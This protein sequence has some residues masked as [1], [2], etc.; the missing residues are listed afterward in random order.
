MGVCDDARSRCFLGI[1]MPFFF[2]I[3][4]SSATSPQPE[5]RPVPPDQAGSTIM[6]GRDPDRDDTPYGPGRPRDFGRVGGGAVVGGM[7]AQERDA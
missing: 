2:L 7:S 5:D 6:A 3:S 4:K 1:L